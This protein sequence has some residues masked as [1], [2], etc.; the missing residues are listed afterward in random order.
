MA[1]VLRGT[2]KAVPIKSEPVGQA[3]QKGHMEKW[4]PG[5]PPERDCLPGTKPGRGGSRGGGQGWESVWGRL[6]LS[7]NTSTC[8]QR[9]AF[10]VNECFINK[11]KSRCQPREAFRELACTQ[12]LGQGRAR[13]GLPTTEQASAL[14]RV[15]P[16]RVDQVSVSAVNFW[17]NKVQV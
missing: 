13:K 8:M 1:R 15:T 11:G 3:V 14:V 2:R 4:H 9:W 12:V 7:V 6:Y 17:R 10:W 5:W 16:A